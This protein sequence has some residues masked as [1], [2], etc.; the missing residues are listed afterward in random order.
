MSKGT[1][2]RWMKD[3]GFRR[4]VG[5]MPA[6][7][8]RAFYSACDVEAGWVSV[9]LMPDYRL[10]EAA[11]GEIVLTACVRWADGNKFVVRMPDAH[12]FTLA[13]IAPRCVASLRTD[14]VDILERPGSVL[15]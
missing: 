7:G 11:L 5:D 15:A 9:L 6:P 1:I 3:E 2:V 13:G 10:S 12:V 4:L 14:V 8:A